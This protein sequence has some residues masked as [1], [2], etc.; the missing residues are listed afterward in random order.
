MLG[1]VWQSRWKLGLVKVRSLLVGSVEMSELVGHLLEHRS[2]ITRPLKFVHAV[3]EGKA[4]RL[5]GEKDAVAGQ[6]EENVPQPGCGIVS[7]G[8]CLIVPLFWDTL[9]H[10]RVDEA[11]AKTNT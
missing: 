11:P 2:R 4:G 1:V 7:V 10:L 5:G 6:E 9:G 8:E 3:R